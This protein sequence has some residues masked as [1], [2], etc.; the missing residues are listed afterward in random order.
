MTN[1]ITGTCSDLPGS[2]PADLDPLP[3]ISRPHMMASIQCVTEPHS[4]IGVLVLAT[5][6]ML[7]ELI[8]ILQ[9]VGSELTTSPGEL[10]QGVQVQMSCETG[11]DAALR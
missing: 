6:T 8:A 1:Q 10:V 11:R 4:R 7:D 3:T 2:D 9:Q 5:Q